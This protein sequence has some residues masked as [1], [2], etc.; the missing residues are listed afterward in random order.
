MQ[1]G[2]FLPLWAY[3][4]VMAYVGEDTGES[5]NKDVLAVWENEQAAL[6]AA[7]PAGETEQGDAENNGDFSG[8]STGSGE[9]TAETDPVQQDTGQSAALW[10]RQITI[11]RSKLL[12]FDYLMQN[13]YRVDRTTT[14]DS[15]ELDPGKLLEQDVSLDLSATGPVVLIYHTHS[16]EG[17]AD[18]DGTDAMSVM[19]L[20]ERLSE[21]LQETYGI[22]TLHHMGKYDVD[23]RD[24]AY[25]NALPDVSRLIEENPSIQVVIDLHR[26]GVEEGT[27]L[28]TEIDGKSTARIMFFNG[29]SRT[30]STGQISSLENPYLQDNLAISLQ[31]QIAAA[32]LYPGFTRPL[33]LKGYRYNMHLCPYAMLIEVGAQT[34]T[35]EEAYLAMEPLANILSFVLLGMDK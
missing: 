12:D 28:V 17:F 23:G 2:F 5:E 18:S 33:F 15:S 9:V 27:R 29:L 7:G 3:A 24:Y 35:Y 14:I 16:Q 22:P 4:P 13:F 10:Q 8:D 1:E 6:A 25:A 11:N 26:D 34:N 30:T 21:L 31:M 32:E 20:G 19:A